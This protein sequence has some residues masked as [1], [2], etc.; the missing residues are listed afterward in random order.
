M[1]RTFIRLIIT[2]KYELLLGIIAMLFFGLFVYKSTTR[3]LAIG[4]YYFD[5][6]IMHQVVHNTAHGKFLE[7]TDPN[8]FFQGNRL[9]YHFDL[10]LALFAPFYWLFDDVRVLLVA[11]AAFLV[12]GAGAVYLLAL[13]EIRGKFLALGLATAYL[14]YFPLHWTMIS[15]FHSVTLATSIILWA[16]YFAETRRF[17]ASFACI[18]LAWLT[19]ENV[20]L[21]T[22]CMGL[23]FM[24]KKER[25]FGGALFLMSAMWFLLVYKG[26]MPYFRGGTHFAEGYYTLNIVDNFFRFFRLE[27]LVYVFTLLK[28]FLFLPLLAPQ[29]LL[30]ALP[31][32]LIVLLSS[33]ENMRVVSYHYTALLTP[34]VFI[35]SIYTLQKLRNVF[36][37]SRYP[38]RLLIVI[39]VATNALFA[40]KEGPMTEKF[41]IKQDALGF[42]K[43][44]QD[45]LRDDA[46]PV[47]T[48]GRLGPFFSG[49]THFYNFLFDYAY[50]SQGITDEQIRGLADHYEKAEYVFIKKSEIRQENEFE[51][52]YYQHLV[53]NSRYEK[54]DDEA[55]IE[56]YKKL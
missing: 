4:A 42:V 48:T 8:F 53:N 54:V 50:A 5:L 34:F 10:I 49:R 39:I 11:Q 43:E 16:F 27:T 36:V 6:G 1:D 31:E 47:A 55:G 41:P 13:R 2:R 40:W 52:L 21:V 26:I 45:V 18:F 46:I 25:R 12:S 33:N 37:A 24:W 32:W 29:I 20:P 22:A 30:I 44:W 7:M 19:K 15:D 56:V 3:Y 14:L 23:Y 38:M 9:G 17:S 35:A 28:S 51:W